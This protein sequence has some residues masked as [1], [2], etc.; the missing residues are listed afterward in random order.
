M[1]QF[2]DLMVEQVKHESADAC[3]FTLQV[4]PELRQQFAFQAGQFLTFK[5]P[6][7]DNT[8]IEHLLRC[9]SMS[10]S[11]SADKYVQV[12]VKRVSGG[13]VSNWMCDNVRTGDTLSVMPPAGVFTVKNRNDDLLLFAG[14]SGITPVY[15]ILK[16]ALVESS[17]HIRLVYANRDVDS[18]LFRH[19]LYALQKRYSERFEIVHLLDTLQHYPSQALLS[20]L[21]YNMEHAQV[22]ICGPGPFMD[23]VEQA[24]HDKSF[25]PER[26]HIERFISLTSPQTDNMPQR[27]VDEA[28]IE[29][30][31]IEVDYYGQTHR[32]TCLPTETI[33]QAAQKAQVELP[34]SC[35]V[36]MCASCMCEIKEGKVG[37][38]CNEVLS[39]RDLHNQM[40]LTCQ[41]VPKTPTIKLEFT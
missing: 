12:C 34:F 10:S 6:Y 5:I 3:S 37:L 41:A 33:L 31:A 38:L 14:G 35:E 24:L 17:N 2:Y 27:D 39:E 19:E 11:P 25:A 28:L 20:A 8:E 21:T 30:A 7:Q 18:I 26:I 40:T 23:T 4:P 16:T 9:Y 32:F 36:G 29:G 1:P 15:S 13:K 22:Y